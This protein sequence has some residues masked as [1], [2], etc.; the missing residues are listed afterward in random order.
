MAILPPRSAAAQ[1]WRSAP[2][3]TTSSARRARCWRA[4]TSFWPATARASWSCPRSTRSLPGTAAQTS[5]RPSAAPSSAPTWR[6]VRAI[7]VCRAPPSCCTSCWTR[8]AT[9]CSPSAT[10]AWSARAPCPPCPA[11]PTPTSGRPRSRT[12]CSAGCSPRFPGTIPRRS[13]GASACCTAARPS[14]WSVT[15]TSLTRRT[16]ARRG[17]AAGSPGTRAPA[18]PTCMRRWRATWWSASRWESSPTARSCPPS[19]AWRSPTAPPPPPSRRRS[20]C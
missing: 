8:R 18:A 7:G 20:A 12:T 2:R 16:P 17:E 3:T 13:S 4:G 10:P 9:R 5:S 11:S 19:R 15:S 14:T 1:P 6:T